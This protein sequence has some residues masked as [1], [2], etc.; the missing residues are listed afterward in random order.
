MSH[1]INWNQLLSLYACKNLTYSIDVVRFLC[2]GAE[3]AVISTQ[4]VTLINAALFADTIPLIQYAT[5]STTPTLSCKKENVLFIACLLIGWLVPHSL[6]S[7]SNRLSITHSFTHSFIHSFI[8]SL[9]QSLAR[10]LA[11]S[12]H[13]FIHPFRK[14]PF[15]YSSIQ[16][17]IKRLHLRNRNKYITDRGS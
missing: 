10:S 8:H 14:H 15:V 5:V 7:L 4:L 16:F 13:S 17:F 2:S 12:F 3:V 1:V 6:V 11:H 9:N